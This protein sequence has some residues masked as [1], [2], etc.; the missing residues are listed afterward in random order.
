MI[1]L[2]RRFLLFFLTLEKSKTVFEKKYLPNTP[3]KS[4]LLLGIISWY[5]SKINCCLITKTYYDINDSSYSKL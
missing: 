3:A 1:S 4:N 2:N 5:V